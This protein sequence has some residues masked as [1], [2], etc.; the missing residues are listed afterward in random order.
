MYTQEYLNLSVIRYYR[1]IIKTRL[2]H[3]PMKKDECCCEM[4]GL[5]SFL[6]LFLISRKPICGKE[7]ADE[8][9]ERK[10]L[11]PSPGTIYPALKHLRE[12]G[13][14]DEKKEGKTINYALSTQGQRAF[15][16]AK[17]QFCKT[18]KE[19]L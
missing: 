6:I 10:G 15:K 18:F 17:Q 14:I 9:Q 4:R 19:L 7:I 2:R 5:L 11:R 13:F 3:N 1:K 8:I 16:N 12:H